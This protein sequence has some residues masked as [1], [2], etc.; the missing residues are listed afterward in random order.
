MDNVFY[1]NILLPYEEKGRIVYDTDWV[2]PPMKTVQE[3]NKY[4]SKHPD[5]DKTTPI[6]SEYKVSKEGG[7][8]SVADY[9]RDG[10]LVPLVEYNGT[11]DKMWKKVAHYMCAVHPLILKSH[12]VE[13][14]AAFFQGIMHKAL[15]NKQPAYCNGCGGLYPELVHHGNQPCEC[16]SKFL[17]YSEMLEQVNWF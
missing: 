10:T 14:D 8:D 13:E 17:T 5:L 11:W 15:E 9:Y 3:V 1:G 12:L 16:G 2:T 7:N 4:L 6:I